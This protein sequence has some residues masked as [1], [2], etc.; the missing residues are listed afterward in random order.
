MNSDHTPDLAG[1]L[2]EPQG[3]ATSWGL[4]CNLCGKSYAF[5]PMVFGCPNCAHEN[6]IGV[7]DLTFA[8]SS[9]VKPLSA[10]H[11]YGIS[12]YRDLLPAGNQPEWISLGEGGTPLLLS[13]NIGPALGLSRLYFKNESSNPTGSFKDRFV[14]VSINNARYFGF[15]KV[16]TTST[17]NLGVSV[18]AYA[19]ACGMD[20]AIVLPHEAPP[21]IV[22]EL[23]RFGAQVFI[24]T[25]ARRIQVF[26]EIAHSGAWFPIFATFQRPVQNPFGIDGYKTLAYELTE[27]LGSAPQIVLFPCARGNG[28]YGAWKGFREVSRYGWS[29]AGPAM[30]ACQPVG[31]NSLEVSLAQGSQ[32]SIELPRAT[33]IAKSAAEVVASDHALVAVRESGGW[34][35]SASD[36]EIQSATEEL[37]REGLSIETSA[38]LSIAGLKQLVRRNLVPQN[39]AVVCVLTASGL[40][41]PVTPPK[42]APP[43]LNLPD[44]KSALDLL[45]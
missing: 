20:C 1:S 8:P 17:G 19:A 10:R 43:V 18:A 33:S 27:Q 3:E 31:S 11:G 45:R 44:D 40:R 12:R 24:T 4:V 41:W 34:A 22:D 28:L 5:G 15:E 2:K 29:L 32:H 23:R 6:K 36:D 35:V 39:A 30:V 26:E 7:L 37:L 16:V 25:L 9:T 38:A 42:G 21:A 13:R 14:C